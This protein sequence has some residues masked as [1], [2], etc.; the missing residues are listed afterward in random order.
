MAKA[1]VDRLLVESRPDQRAD[2]SGSS[3]G[4]Y[5]VNERIRLFAGEDSGLEIRSSEGK[6]TTVTVELK[7]VLAEQIK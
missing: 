3:Y 1:L 6:G 5:N 4:L 2:G 7:A